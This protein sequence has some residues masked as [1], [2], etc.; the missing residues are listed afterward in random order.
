MNAS[1]LTRITQPSTEHSTHAGDA[2]SH[3]LHNSGVFKLL[4]QHEHVEVD[5]VDR[6]ISQHHSRDVVDP[7][8]RTGQR[9]L[10]GYPP[11]K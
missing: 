11:P 9:A 3:V 6:Q 1:D 8:D 5:V 4:G 7:D 2:L 10:R